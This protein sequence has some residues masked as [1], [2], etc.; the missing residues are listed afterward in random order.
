[1]KFYLV[2]GEV[3]FLTHKVEYEQRGETKEREF[4]DVEKKDAFLARLIERN[5]EHTVTEI[6]QPT[7]EVI[8][9][10]AGRRFETVAH[11]QKAI[12]GTEEPAELDVALLA[13]A[14]LYEMVSGGAE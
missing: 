14:E 11:A 7:Q 9:K 1:M 13:I 2:S 8:D 12:D 6:D 3:K 10:V 4:Y 5:V